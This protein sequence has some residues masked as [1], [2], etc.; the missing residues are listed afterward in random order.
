MRANKEFKEDLRNILGRFGT[1]R[2]LIIDENG[3][4]I[5]EHAKPPSQ[6]KEFEKQLNNI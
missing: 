6:I 5:E 1:P 4:I 3:N 2:Y